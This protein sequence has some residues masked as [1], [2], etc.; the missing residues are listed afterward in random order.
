M[1]NYCIGKVITH[2]CSHW[3]YSHRK[4]SISIRWK[5]IQRIL[6]LLQISSCIKNFILLKY[7]R[8]ILFLW[9]N[10]IFVLNSFFWFCYTA[11]Y[12]ISIFTNRAVTRQTQSLT[13]S[14]LT[15]KQRL[16]MVVGS[17]SWSLV[18]SKNLSCFFS[19]NALRKIYH[20]KGLFALYFW[21]KTLHFHTKVRQSLSKILR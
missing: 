12:T 11:H 16:V 6:P 20:N 13:V 7:D 4:T 2:N 14:N 21:Q 19:C 1:Y 10:Y 17:D 5:E 3:H 15:K 9:K 18:I 8:K